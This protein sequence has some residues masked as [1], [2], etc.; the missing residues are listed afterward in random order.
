MDIIIDMCMR[1]ESIKLTK[2]EVRIAIEEE[3]KGG[4]RFAI[5]GQ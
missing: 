3:R 5:V 2:Y 4:G 1:G